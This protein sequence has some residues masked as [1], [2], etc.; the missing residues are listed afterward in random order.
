MNEDAKP[1]PL[2][3]SGRAEI[4]RERAVLMMNQYSRISVQHKVRH[5][6]QDFVFY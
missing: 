6:E 4:E 2:R 3:Y 5:S 1:S